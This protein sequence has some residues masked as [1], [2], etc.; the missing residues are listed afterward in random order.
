MD[1]K[2]LRKFFITKRRE[3]ICKAKKDKAITE[4]MLALPCLKNATQVLLF[5]STDEEFNTMEIAEYCKANDKII[6]YPRCLE[7]YGIMEFYRLA[8]DSDL[9]LHKYGILA[10]VATCEGYIE[11]ENDVIIVPAL[12][13]DG[14]H[15]RLGYGGG[16]YDRFLKNFNGVSICPVYDE[17]MVSALPTD[18]NDIKVSIIATDKE[19]IL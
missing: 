5:A 11:K 14:N 17:L 12:S 8:K 2:A 19:V 13:A 4:K 6:F 15:Y 7:E 9:I 1:K 3:I 10:P 18:K 16:Y